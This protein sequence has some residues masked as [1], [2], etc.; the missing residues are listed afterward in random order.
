MP[1]AMLGS[2]Y[3]RPY[4]PTRSFLRQSGQTAPPRSYSTLAESD[5]RRP[6]A[7]EG[8]RGESHGLFNDPFALTVHLVVGLL[9]RLGR[10]ELERKSSRS[11]PAA[12]QSRHRPR[13]APHWV[14]APKWPAAAV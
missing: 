14:C 10:I 6:Q 13:S 11:F 5:Q 4:S 2:G 7:K 9:L 12:K 1:S 8:K 3:T